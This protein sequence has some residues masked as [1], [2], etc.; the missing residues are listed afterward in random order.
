MTNEMVKS[1]KAMGNLCQILNRNRG[2]Q[3]TNSTGFVKETDAGICPHCGKKMVKHIIHEG[4]RYHV[5]SYIGYT[6]KSRSPVT[7]SNPNCEDNHG[8]GRCVDRDGKPYERN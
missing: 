4:A 3:K 2:T 1:V 6:D 7:C 5:H 8:I